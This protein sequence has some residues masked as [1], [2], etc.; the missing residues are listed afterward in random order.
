M[1]YKKII[2]AVLCFWLHSL[3]AT[4]QDASELAKRFGSLPLCRAF[5]S[6]L[7]LQYPTRTFAVCVTQDNLPLIVDAQYLAPCEQ[8]VDQLAISTRDVLNRV[9]QSSPVM[10]SEPLVNAPMTAF[11]AAGMSADL[12][13][14]ELP[15]PPKV[16]VL[17]TVYTK[18]QDQQVKPAPVV[19]VRPTLPNSPWRSVL[20][21]NQTLCWIFVMGLPLS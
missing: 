16:V 8:V 2:S 1:Q 11:H 9:G 5:L 6:Q 4:T 13:Y 18:P 12:G 3:A 21:E 19:N 14:Y 17:P 7:V 15:H 20:P 10:S